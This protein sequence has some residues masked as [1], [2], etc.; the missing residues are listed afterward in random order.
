MN[1]A[2]HHVRALPGP[3][4]RAR[5]PLAAAMAASSSRAPARARTAI[6]N[7]AYSRVATRAARAAAARGPAWVSADPFF[8]LFRRRLNKCAAVVR[9]VD[10]GSDGSYE[11]ALAAGWLRVMLERGVACM[12]VFVGFKSTV[13]LSITLS[14][15]T[16][17]G[18]R[19][20]SQ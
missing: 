5:G 7:V 16:P 2:I 9:A 6:Y 18:P 12:E 4:R 20:R 10:A 3:P 15:R 14:P 1:V 8:C 17:V 19:V 13:S 11:Q